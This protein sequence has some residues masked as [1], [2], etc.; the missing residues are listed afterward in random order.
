MTRI[1]TYRAK[2]NTCKHLWNIHIDAGD[3]LQTSSGNTEFICKNCSA[4]ITLSEK[5]ALDSYNSLNDSL[6]IQENHT[7]NGMIANWL[8][9]ILVLIAFITL[10]FGNGIAEKL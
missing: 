3:R 2:F 10:V 8:T 1:T 9:F 4:I 7:K 5:L 6:K